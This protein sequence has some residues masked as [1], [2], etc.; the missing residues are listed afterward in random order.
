MSES[1]VYS[2]ITGKKESKNRE[3]IRKVL[4]IEEL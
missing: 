2:R 3:K 4:E 1:T